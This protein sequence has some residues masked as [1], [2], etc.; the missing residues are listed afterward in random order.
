MYKRFRQWLESNADYDQALHRPQFMSPRFD[1]KKRTAFNVGEKQEDPMYYTLH[2]D[3][4]PRKGRKSPAD[5]LFGFMRK[6]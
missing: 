1:P 5:R 2:K 6:H 4:K 3:E